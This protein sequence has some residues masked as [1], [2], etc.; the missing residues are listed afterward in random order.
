M[1]D[2]PYA[3]K[4]IGKN[5][6]EYIYFR[7]T[8]IMR[9]NGLLPRRLTPEEA[10]A[11]LAK[12]KEEWGDVK[13]QPISYSAEDIRRCAT[14]MFRNAK[15]RATL[16]GIPF[17]ITKEWLERRME[18]C[19]A[20]CEV[21]GIPFD[22]SSARKGYRR[23]WAPS[24]DRI[25]PKG[26]Y[27]PGNARLVCSVVNYARSDWPD[28]VFWQMIHACYEARAAKGLTNLPLKSGKP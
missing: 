7:P 15:G 14:A 4:F 23:P 9:E 20:R 26:P 11:F 3:K 24:I 8:P 5:G 28:E 19:A 18:I 27:S 2:L 21:S 1:S 13:R 6:K 22:L 25:N 10:P 17:T 16:R 12:I